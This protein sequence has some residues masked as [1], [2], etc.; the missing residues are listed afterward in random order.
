MPG[1]EINPNFGAE[2]GELLEMG[3][4]EQEE[5][6]EMGRV[7][8]QQHGQPP[9]YMLQG[10]RMQREVFVPDIAIDVNEVAARLEARN[11]VPDIGPANPDAQAGR[12][13]ADIQERADQLNQE[14]RAQGL[15]VPNS[16]LRE[17]LGL[18]DRREPALNMREANI[19][20]QGAQVNNLNAD[21]PEAVVPDLEKALAQHDDF[22][23]RGGVSP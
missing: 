16:V 18:V 6:V 20:N 23:G 21:I 9:M 7:G 22:G 3:H 8:G 1:F 2:E 4:F 11:A 12:P 17:R 10:P 5:V 19:N 13:P 14:I 15:N